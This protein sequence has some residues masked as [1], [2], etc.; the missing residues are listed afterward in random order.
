MYFSEWERA[1]TVVEGPTV[2]LSV[3]PMRNYPDCFHVC[4]RHH[5]R[6][7]RVV[8]I[9]QKH[10]S[11]LPSVVFYL[12]ISLVQMHAQCRHLD[13]AYICWFAKKS[14]TVLIAVRWEIDRFNYLNLRSADSCVCSNVSCLV[15][16]DAS[17]TITFLCVLMLV[18]LAVNAT[19]QTPQHFCVWNNSYATKRFARAAFTPRDLVAIATWNVD[20]T[21]V[22]SAR[23]F[24]MRTRREPVLHGEARKW[25]GLKF[26]RKQ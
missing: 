21:C 1:C 14:E 19:R 25:Q 7:S 8:R 3:L 22:F 23:L 12:L 6:Y 2:E 26:L 4:S 17:N 20:A 11:C 5:L 24:P 10:A 15:L 18:V 16:S 13:G 9:V